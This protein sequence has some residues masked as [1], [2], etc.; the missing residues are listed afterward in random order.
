[1]INLKRSQFSLIAG[2]LV[3]I[4]LVTVPVPTKAV[5]PILMP[6]LLVGSGTAA[7]PAIA[8]GVMLTPVPIVGAGIVDVPTT[9]SGPT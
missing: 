2:D 6:V 9:A 4:V 3:A 1:M 7:T 5:A 8:V